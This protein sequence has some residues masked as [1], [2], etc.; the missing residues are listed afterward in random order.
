MESEVEQK[1]WRCGGPRV[2]RELLEPVRDGA[3]SIA[4]YHRVVCRMVRLAVFTDRRY[5]LHELGVF[6]ASGTWWHWVSQSRGTFGIPTS[7]AAARSRVD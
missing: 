6:R 3:G 4:S 2:V 5:G 1:Y 7:A